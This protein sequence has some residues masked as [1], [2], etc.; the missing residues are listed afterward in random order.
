[1]WNLIKSLSRN[2]NNWRGWRT[3]R[4][5]VVIESD[6][7]GSICMPSK[8]VYESLLSKGIRVDKCPYATY[9]SLA[10]ENDLTAIFSVLASVEDSRRRPAV[11]TANTIMT[12][13]DFEKI[14][15][16]GFSEYHF[17]LFTDSFSKNGSLFNPLDY[18]NEGKR[19]GVFCPQYHGREHLNVKEWLEQLKEPG[20]VYRKAFTHGVSWLGSAYNPKS[21]I[22]LRATYDT[23]DVSDI[24]EQRTELTQGL[25]L[26][27]ELFKT[28]SESFI[29][30][31]YI[32]HSDLLRTLKKSGVQYIQGM[33][34]L[35]MPKLGNEKHEMK[36]RI[37]G[38][39]NNS[40]QINLVRNCKFE[41]S[42]YPESYDSVGECLK[43]VKNAFL[44]KKPAII[45]SHRMNFIGHVH[46]ENRTR[47]LEL[48]RELLNSIVRKW[49]EVEFMTSAELGKLMSGR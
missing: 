3:D 6:D 29:A 4:K 12:N 39:K 21:G 46:L 8:K 45:C 7:W 14:E 34:Y 47:N 28:N 16:T 13:P 27:R 1:M 20:S 40:Q 33:K 35:V 24:S 19:A 26:F 17:E 36:R 42:Q 18:F 15:E 9:D 37:Q 23:N 38:A 32:L 25:E 2:L 22:N 48:F 43:G 49:P 5:I 44:W 30:P 41:P 11:L 10:N 31:N